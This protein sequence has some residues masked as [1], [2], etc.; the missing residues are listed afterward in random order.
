VVDEI[1]AAGGQAVASTDS[2]TSFEGAKAIV[3]L[4][5]AAFG[6]LHVV[7]NNAGILRDRMLVSMSE[8]EFDDVISV[9]LKGT[10]NITRHAAEV[11]RERSKS[12]D[13]VDRAI[14][15]TSSGAGL[16]GNVGQTNYSAAKAGIAAMTVVNAMELNRYGVR[17]NC[18]APVART[19]LTLQTPGLSDSMNKHVFDPEN[20]SPLV[21]VLASETCPFNG[22]VFS[23]YGGSVGIYGGWSIAEEVSTDDR[24]TPESLASAMDSLPRTVEV[25]SQMTALVKAMQ[26]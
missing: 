25:N 5:V 22:Q 3:D 26:E 2:V 16:H 19:R 11:W 13:I 21:A 24:W 4:A 6:D 12:G 10:F 17:A 1:V 14:V 9:H 18:I 15:N 8:Q 20:I 7:V 23:V